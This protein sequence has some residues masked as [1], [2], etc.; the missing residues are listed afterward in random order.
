MNPEDRLFGQV[1]I[2]LGVLSREAASHC[3]KVQTTERPGLRLFQ[4]ALEL[5]LISKEQQAQ[6]DQEVQRGLEQQR[7]TLQLESKKPP[8]DA[9][10]PPAAD[11]PLGSDSM[12]TAAHKVGHSDSVPPSWAAPL[13]P[14]ISSSSA[15]VAPAPE[16]VQTTHAVEA[17]PRQQ[18]VEQAASSAAQAKAPDSQTV[19]SVRSGNPDSQ[20]AYLVR[21]LAY[22]VKQGASDMHLH[23]GAPL[24]ARIHGRLQPLKG[25]QIINAEDAERM[26]AEILTDEEWNQLGARGEIDFA[27]AVPKCGRFRVNAYRQQ[28]GM[29]IV[30]RIIPEE[31]PTIAQLGLPESI[32]RLVDYRT[33]LVLC[34]GPAGCGKS[35]T[36]SA[37]LRHL[38]DTREEHVLT[39]ENPIEFVFKENAA[40]VNQRQVGDHT[41]SFARALRA[42]LREDPD[43]IAITE[44]RDKE[45]IGLA[46]SA[47]ETGHLVLGT[48]H[49]GNAGQ[50]ISRI[51][52]TFAAEE[53]GHIRTMLSES[54]RAVVSQRLV[55]KA[56]GTGRALA[57]ELL[58]CNNA[59]ANMIRD[60]KMFQISSIMQTG[61]SLGMTILDDSLWDLVTR[62]VV[63]KDE[64]RRFAENKDRFR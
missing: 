50:T 32:S 23:S 42:A 47:A 28:R 29:D 15:S 39:I 2:R 19:R 18:V 36:L 35:T 48:L 64:A 37:L 11:T 4:V 26:I 63:T 20:T 5:K 38:I 49:T 43:V 10:A 9:P 6:V 45:S 7:R 52:N 31:V 16:P 54:L 59:V 12:L 14:L 44:L 24:L 27:Y 56:D 34:T 46:L 13:P 58:M 53:Q 33:G 40:I 41:S 57:W 17:P 25:D 8:P 51:V 55:P 62:G 30:F 21:A 61:R 3:L 22:A 60:D 1:A